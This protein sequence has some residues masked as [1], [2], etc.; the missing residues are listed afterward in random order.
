MTLGFSQK[1]NGKPNYFPEKIIAGLD[2]P[3]YK[4]MTLMDSLGD[5]TGRTDEEFNAGKCNPLFPHVPKRHTI[6]L[7]PKNRWRAGMAIHPVINSRTKDRYQFAPVMKCKRCQEISIVYRGDMP[8]FY[9]GNRLL[10]SANFNDTGEVYGADD[11]LRL[12]LNDGFE[13]TEEFYK[14]FN[15]DFK[16]KIIH[17]TDLIY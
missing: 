3:D 4:K 14:Y 11:M 6:R 16:G 10:Y 7:D 12:A 1:I 15:N 13:S 8:N 17:W 9:I 5:V 2:L